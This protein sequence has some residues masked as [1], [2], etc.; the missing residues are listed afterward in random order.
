M[1]EQGHYLIAALCCLEFLRRV[2]SK[3]K[4]SLEKFEDIAFQTFDRTM[5]E[6]LELEKKYDNETEHRLNFKVQ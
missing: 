3:R 5:K 2:D 4:N 6:F 1:H